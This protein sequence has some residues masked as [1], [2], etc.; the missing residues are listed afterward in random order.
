MRCSRSPSPPT[1]SSATKSAKDEPCC[2][3]AAAQQGPKQREKAGPPLLKGL[4]PAPLELIAV[5]LNALIGE[6]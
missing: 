4:R 1:E 2:A 6:R 5:H 3:T